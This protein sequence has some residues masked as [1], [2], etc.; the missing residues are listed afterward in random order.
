MAVTRTYHNNGSVYPGSNNYTPTGSIYLSTTSTVD[1]SSGDYIALLF[2]SMTSLNANS[3]GPRIQGASIQFDWNVN[4]TFDQGGAILTDGTTTAERTSIKPTNVTKAATITAIWKAIPA[5]VGDLN[6]VGARFDLDVD[7]GIGIASLYL[8]RGCDLS[9]PASS[10]VSPS[11]ST[12]TS[13][14]GTLVIPTNGVG[15][16]FVSSNGTEHTSWEWI[17]LTE[18]VDTGGGYSPFAGTAS[19]TTAGSSTRTATAVG[20]S[21]SSGDRSMGLLLTAFQEPR[22]Q[23]R[24]PRIINQTIKRSR[25]W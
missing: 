17:G 23:P 1:V 2:V 21:D 24:P 20:E 10:V 11:N 15:I 3:T 7:F 12:S 16:G 8:V 22:S 19:S 13:I 4:A 14:A 5:S 6:S 25:F 18:D 9:S